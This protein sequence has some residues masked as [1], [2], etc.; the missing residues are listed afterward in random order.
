MLQEEAFVEVMQVSF[1]SIYVK[2]LELKYICMQTTQSSTS[3]ASKNSTLHDEGS[4]TRFKSPENKVNDFIK[5]FAA[6][7]FHLTGH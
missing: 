3:A 5:G 6:E 1:G 2:T 4:N 7:L